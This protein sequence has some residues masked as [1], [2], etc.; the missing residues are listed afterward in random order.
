MEAVTLSRPHLVGEPRDALGHELRMFDD[1]DGVADDSE[2]NRVCE[3][4]SIRSS[5]RGRLPAWLVRMVATRFRASKSGPVARVVKGRADGPADAAGFWLAF[6]TE[7]SQSSALML[8]G[9]GA[10]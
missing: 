7:R 8:T 4:A 1:V 5:G 6:V 2:A 10:S 3:T 9:S